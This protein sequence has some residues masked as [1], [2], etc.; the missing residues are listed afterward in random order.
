MINYNNLTAN[1][2]DALQN[3]TIGKVS[4]TLELVT[5][6]REDNDWYNLYTTKTCPYRIGFSG[7]NRSKMEMGG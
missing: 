2:R 1:E 4:V 7:R 6:M 3:D 5:K